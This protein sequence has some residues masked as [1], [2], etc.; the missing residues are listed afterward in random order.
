M[1]QPSVTG[2]PETTAEASGERP[3]RVSDPLY[4]LLEGIASVPRLE[5]VAELSPGDRLGRF[6]VLH[7]IGRGGFGIVYRARD[8]ELGRHVA[9]KM[10]RFVPSADSREGSALFELFRG[11]AEAAARLSHPNAITIH[12]IGNSGGLPYL[13]L[14]LLQGETLETRLARG[15]LSTAEAIEILLPI[16]R[17]LAHAHRAGVIHRDLKPSNVFLCEDGRVKILDFGLARL[18]HAMSTAQ[19]APVSA[20]RDAPSS[21]LPGAGTAA[22]MAPEQWRGETEDERT[23][24]F[25][26]GVILF[27][28]LSGQLPYEL[29]P[30]G[31]GGVLS[32]HPPPSLRAHCPAVVPSMAALAERAMAKERGARLQSAE[33]LEEA[34]VAAERSL[35]ATV[36]AGAPPY[37]YLEPFSE[38]DGAWFFG[39]DRETARLEQMLS[40]RA[41]VAVVGPSGAGKSSL[42]EAGLIPRLRRGSERWEIFALRPGTDPLRLLHARLPPSLLPEGAEAL[43]EKPGRLGEALRTLA[44]ERGAK[45]MLFLDQ[46]EELVTLTARP[47]IQRAFVRAVLSAGDD[48]ASPTR[49]V[50]TV[51]DDF[52]G[53][54][55][56]S[57]DLGDVLVPGMLLLGPPD[58]ASLAACLR[59]PAARLGYA[60]DEGLVEEIVSALGKELA[61]LPLLQLAASRLWERRETS[62]R[63]L[64]RAALEA[65]GGVTGVL[66]A[67]ANEVLHRLAGVTESKIARR[68]LC[69][70]TTPEG[71]RRQVSSAELLDR[72]ESRE[73]AARVLEQL[74][75]GRLLTTSKGPQGEWVELVHESLITSWDQLR[76]WL[77]E[78]RGRRVLS[79]RISQGALHWDERGRPKQLLWTGE[80]LEDALRWR[81][82]EAG[83]LGAREAAFLAAAEGIAA[84]ARRLRRRLFASG[85]LAALLTIFG[86]AMGTWG[87]RRTARAER[88][89]AI[90]HA[91]EAADDPQLA[92]LLL[93]EIENGPEPPGGTT[94]AYR[95]LGEPRPIEVH[96][97]RPAVLGA[98]F[99]PDGRQ[100]ATMSM[101]GVVRN[102]ATT[103]RSPP[104]ELRGHTDRNSSLVFSPDGRALLSASWD[105]TARVW[106]TD[107]A[108]EPIVLAGHGGA[109]MRAVFSPDGRQVATAAGDGVRIWPAR[110]GRPALLAGPSARASSVSFSPDGSRLIAVYEDHNAWMW[111]VATL[112]APIVL[113]GHEGTILSAEFGPDGRQVVT[114]SRDQTARIWDREGKV[115]QVLRG[116][117]A[118]VRMAV[119]SPRG[120]RIVTVSDDGTARLWPV[121]GTG[122]PLVLRGHAGPVLHAAFDRDGSR[123]VTSSRDR[124]ARIWPVAP[125]HSSPGLPDEP[126]VLRGHRTVVWMASF[127]PDGER[128]LT[129]SDDPAVR[130][131]STS[132]PQARALRVGDYLREV[133]MDPTGSRLVVVYQDGTARVW[134]EKAPPWW[135]RGHESA[136]LKA[137]FSP[138]GTRIVTASADA[139][140]RVWSADGGGEPV[141]L[142]GH[143][144]AIN[145]AR[146]SPNGRHVV[147]A[148]EDSTARVWRADGSG[149][150]VVLRGHS[151]PLLC[152]V[153]DGEGTRLLTGSADRTARVW[154][155]DGSGELVVLSGHQGP[156]TQVSLSPD[157]LR[158]VTASQD[159]TARVWS[160]DGSP[161]LVL[162]N[163]GR[164]W[165]AFFDPRGDRVVTSAVTPRIWRADGSG[166]PIA[167]VERT[168]GAFHA[169]FTDDGTRVV[170][171]A[172]DRNV[173]IWRADGTG[174][175][176]VL[177]GHEGLL[178][179]MDVTGDRIVSGSE[180]GS[181]LIRPIR[182]WAELLAHLRRTTHDCL[183][184]EQREQ[185]LGESHEEAEAASR[186]C[187]RALAASASP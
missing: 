158:A 33:A 100:I 41:L 57:P 178:R 118:A 134:S 113:R 76:S 54:L 42:I 8:T 83:R 142:R 176:V 154:R 171:A 44:K 48:A 19:A 73:A 140:A 40:V 46:M 146:F 186:R 31:P 109:V 125:A 144:G 39:R 116:H 26:V 43:L 166:E 78:D 172:R 169:A 139:T 45:V 153:F 58:A 167:L 173:R 185:H 179:R 77:E 10:M 20:G 16:A 130:V 4:P 11:E 60:F 75:A 47:E 21:T 131:W 114:A 112:R 127:S 117:T 79:E 101:D 71:T 110:G 135:M 121:G 133:Q 104:R 137:R 3:H 124:T 145:A 160:F 93:L 181:V 120:D 156:V 92:A 70:L 97:G 165:T 129:A 91:A 87:Y 180:D 7:E 17:G 115:V 184:V 67:H 111:Q 90:V 32:A 86:L 55:S 102:W 23:D 164:V 106:R 108:G 136:I 28:M 9:V 12:D 170:T 147:T 94:V 64:T 161:P 37:R 177:G 72:A 99:S 88:A 52:L 65:V 49:V 18:V 53:R 1:D 89:K 96:R 61:P 6:Q 103:K 155:A 119:F 66:A 187:E 148:S 85:I 62:A 36:T 122:E 84:R 82:G 15:T 126:L 143:R 69:D 2:A 80:V 183:T 152:A 157:G 27:Q 51:R 168:S 59:E 150:A 174:E 107:G 34:L 74:I 159:W 81:S 98:A 138:D 95:L 182:T 35:A 151:G 13:V 175:P 30:S 128:V 50:L 29:P 163:D 22:Y 123:V 25:A 141:V 68:I 132:R 105:G 38:S 14:E 162:Q 149:S 63:R 24:L 56:Q 5:K